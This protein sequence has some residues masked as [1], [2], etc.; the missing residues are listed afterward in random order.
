MTTRCSPGRWSRAALAGLALAGLA[1]ASAAVDAGLGAAHASAQTGPVVGVGVRLLDE[2]SA[3]QDD[4]R[5]QVYIVDHLAPGTTIQRRIEV[6]NAG[7]ADQHVVLYAAAATI[8]HGSFVGVAGHHANDL[9]S[10]SSVSPGNADVA[11]SG[12]ATVT[13][14][15]A[16]PGDAAPGEQYGV[17]W[18]ETRSATAPESGVVEVSRVGIRL[19]VSIGPGGPPAA[20]FSI[21]TLTAGRSHDGRPL[22]SALVHNTGGRALDM[23]G[24]LDL[25]AGPGGLRAGPFPATLGSTLG[26]GDTQPVTVHLDREL[27]AG[28]WDAR[29][30]LKSGLTERTATA[31]ITFPASGRAD[32]VAVDQSDSPP[33]VLF[34]AGVAI[35]LLLLGIGW[36]L[37]RR[38]TARAASV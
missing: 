12:T 3:A 37:R 27:P 35:L 8:E 22:V 33:W 7:T 1:L 34:G 15:I 20:D 29:V 19:Y 2:P 38:R 10:W 17:V 31:T 23:N 24:S 21:D 13:V 5:A 25:A 4:P 26:L 9:S 11:A 32:P 36:R 30:T 16:V 18:A 14:T 6:S 28:P